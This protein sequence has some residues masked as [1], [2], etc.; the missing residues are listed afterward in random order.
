M[1]K[2]YA[3]SYRLVTLQKLL[4]FLWYIKTYDKC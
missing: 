1:N 2:F 4:L 3:G